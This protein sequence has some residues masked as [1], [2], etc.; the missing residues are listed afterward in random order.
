MCKVLPFIICTCNAS[1]K[2]LQ[3][4]GQLPVGESTHLWATEAAFHQRSTVW[5]GLVR[6]GLIQYGTKLCAFQLW[7][8]LG[9]TKITDRY[10]PGFWSPFHWGTKHTDPACKG[11]RYDTQLFAI[12]LSKAEDEITDPYIMFLIILLSGY[13]AHWYGSEK[14]GARHTA[15]L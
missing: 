13:E 4:N 9:N 3:G 6:F 11:W 8:V 5:F 14:G 10:H 12:R 1:C 15:V 2:G 7:K